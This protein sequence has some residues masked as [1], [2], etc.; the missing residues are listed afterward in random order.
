M[1]F[2]SNQGGEEEARQKMEEMLTFV[3]VN[4]LTVTKLNEKISIM[5]REQTKMLNRIQELERKITDLERRIQYMN[6]P[7]SLS[8]QVNNFV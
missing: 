8:N 5:E 6:F 7:P 2:N 3:D 4:S 1:I